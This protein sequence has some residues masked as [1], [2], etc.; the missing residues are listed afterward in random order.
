MTIA[1]IRNELNNLLSTDSNLTS[2]EVSMASNLVECIPTDIADTFR[3]LP[4]SRGVNLVNDT[5]ELVIHHRCECI[6]LFLEERNSFAQSLINSIE[7]FVAMYAV[8]P[9]FDVLT[10]TE[11]DGSF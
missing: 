1:Q 6:E 4:D 11:A 2:N 10:A 3:V 7:K 9:R 5:M 8:P